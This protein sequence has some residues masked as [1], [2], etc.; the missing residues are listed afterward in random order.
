MPPKGVL[1][2]RGDAPTRPATSSATSASS[3]AN[4]LTSPS[5]TLERP[6]PT[7][8]V[9]ELAEIHQDAPR[10]APALEKKSGSRNPPAVD[11]GGRASAVDLP[12]SPSSA[13]R[14][15]KEKN[16][17]FNWV[18]AFAASLGGTLFGYEIGI[19]DQIL[20]MDD[21]KLTFGLGVLNTS[22]IDSS[23][24]YWI[25]ETPRFRV[26]QSLITSSFL[27]GCVLGAGVVSVL[28]DRI[29]RKLSILIGGF[30]FTVGGAGQTF[31]S[32]LP[33]LVSFRIMSGI[34]IG[35]LSMSVPLY[36]SESAP[37]EIRGKLTTIYQLM[38]T[39]GIFVAS[40]VNG[41]ILLVF[42]KH[43]LSPDEWRTAFGMQMIP[44]TLLFFIMLAMPRSPR[45]LA[46]KGYH[47]EGL[48]TIARL[49]GLPL[50]SRRVEVE[51][52]QIR[53]G[54]EFERQIGT[55]SWSELF[56]LGV[57]RRLMLGIC[58][59]FWQQWTGINFF[60][61]YAAQLF[62]IILVTED[63][64][65]TQIIFV[66]VNAFINMVSTIP[67]MWGVERYGR[68]PLLIWGGIAMTISHLVVFG[69]A[70]ASE[71]YNN[72]GC[73]W[74]AVF[75]ILCFTATFAYSWGPVVWT[76][77]SEIFPLRIRAK[78]TGLST[79]SNWI[80]NAVIAFIAPI[81]LPIFK[82]YFY[83]FFACVCLM[84]TFYTI[85]FI[86]ETRGRSLEEM[87]EVF[88]DNMAVISTGDWD[89]RYEHRRRLR[90]R[91]GAGGVYTGAGSELELS[92]RSSISSRT[93]DGSIAK[94]SLKKGREGSWDA[95]MAAGTP[96]P[97]RRPS[98]DVEAGVVD[99]D[100]ETD[101]DEDHEGEEEADEEGNGEYG[102]KE[103]RDITDREW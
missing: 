14:V 83:L 7:P 38:I 77:Q 59:Q 4:H 103:E 64:T 26:Y 98:G 72:R 9:S 25:V 100:D 32:I 90:R 37:R 21:F 39:F 30:S 84:M 3:L 86:P 75:G 40:C 50:D 99:D 65:V 11:T 56:R 15:T 52:G 6:S 76:Y 94:G 1:R 69:F 33:V 74:V 31:S 85:K 20:I 2:K 35:I 68:R 34:S 49:R 43:S 82:I 18:V 19:I 67:G 16:Y 5:N 53:A 47:D 87:D 36:I 88:G 93:V 8:E 27:F 17:N 81:L 78:G 89:W 44:G 51:Y 41:I 58:N 57:R 63:P 28:A 79:M 24:P 48:R 80:W 92:S 70:S 23:D 71:A 66:I 102:G 62:A 97:A 12:S 42:G 46:E 54:V 13:S 55:A 101:E 22:A 60:L 45:W 73:A 10:S 91:N 95:R 61:Y 96:L 29:G